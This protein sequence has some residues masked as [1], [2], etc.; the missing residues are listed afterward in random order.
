MEQ[1][2]NPRLIKFTVGLFLFCLVVFILIMAKD[3]LTPIAWALM[4]SLASLR[5]LEKMH[6]KLRINWGLLVL[7]HLMVLLLIIFGVLTFLFT[8]VRLIILNSPEL[9]DKIAM[10]DSNF[11]YWLSR[12]GVDTE[13]LFNLK[14]L[15]QRLSDFSQFLFQLVG[16]VGHVFGDIVLTLIYSFFILFYKDVMG[17]F[18][19]MRHHDEAKLKRIQ[20][21]ANNS[22]SIISNYLGGTLIMTV[23]MG[24]LIYILLVILGIKYAIFWATFAAILNL[25][26][27]IGNA[28]AL[29]A[30]AGYAFLTKDG[31][32]YPVLAVASL[33]FANA[34]QENILRPLV[35]GD[36]LSLNALTV[37]IS[38][39]VGGIIWGVSGMIL[40][41]PVAG[42]IKIILEGK[43]STRPYALF[44]GEPK[45][46]IFEGN[47]TETPD[48]LVD[49][50]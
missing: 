47:L 6:R 29:V 23:L 21:F 48:K 19:H 45:P 46:E 15:S 36:R 16:N 24:V 44:F 13:E 8:E 10:I 26:P 14:T 50:G 33:V 17:Q 20:G 7:I 41:I 42:I 34:I 35:V 32:W 22:L 4:I 31:L 12:M 30:L 49:G 27:Y 5:F 11:V 43:E 39:I 40:F 25:I 28:L 1:A 2:V 37:F 18:I 3:F 38:V 9:E